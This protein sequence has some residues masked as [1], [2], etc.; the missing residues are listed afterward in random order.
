M[1]LLWLGWIMAIPCS[2]ILGQDYSSAPVPAPSAPSQDKLEH[3]LRAAAHLAAAGLPEDATKVWQQAEQESKAVKKEMES[4]RAEVT[5]LRRTTGDTRTVLIHLR[6]IEIARSKLRLL[7]FD[8]AKIGAP[9]QS[10]A[11]VERGNV[12]FPVLDALRKDNLLKVLADPTLVTVSGRPAS[13]R[14]GG[15]IPVPVERNGNIAAEFKPYGTEVNVLPVILPN[16]TLRIGLTAKFSELDRRQEIRVQNLTIPCLRSCEISTGVD[17]RPGQTFV[18][19]GLVGHRATEEPKANR[20]P[21]AKD[22]SEKVDSE[23]EAN[24]IE[25][26]VLITAEIAKEGADAPGITMPHK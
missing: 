18:V 10:T 13:F 8:F 9:D 1:R 19:S 17:L 24:E 14:I 6:A 23:K 15:A 25:L 12:L 22:G 3:L 20:K 21:G 11:V 4:L 26:W 7:G 5:R 2:A 16:G